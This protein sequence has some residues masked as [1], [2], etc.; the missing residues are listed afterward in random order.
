MK[1][2]PCLLL[3]D[4][5][6]RQPPPSTLATAR[7]TAQ[8]TRPTPP[9]RLEA[10]SSRAL[11]TGRSRRERDRDWR[12]SAGTSCEIKCSKSCRGNGSS[13]RTRT[14]AQRF[15]RRLERRNHLLPSDRG[16]RVQKFLD[17][18][19]S[20]QVIDEISERDACALEGR[21]AAEDVGVAGR[22]RST[23]AANHRVQNIS[24][25]EVDSGGLVS[26]RVNRQKLI[27]G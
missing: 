17:T 20:L 11:L 16:K 4:C 13:N 14:A 5:Q 1:R 22:R 18:V 6:T 9:E 24:K 10:K 15:M 3:A 8:S 25:T 27:T 21:C 2:E 7:E 26:T 19:A 12:D 23:T